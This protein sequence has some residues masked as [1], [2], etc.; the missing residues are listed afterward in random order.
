ML[1]WWLMK[2]AATLILLGA[3]LLSAQG[4]PQT[5]YQQI[6]RSFNSVNKRLLDMAKDFPEAKYNF[7]ATPDVRSFGEV[8]IHA[9]SGDVYAAKKGRGENVQW[10]EV[11][12]KQY[13]SKA[14][15]VAALEKAINDA[16]TTLNAIPPDRFKENVQPWVSVI[17]HCGEHYGQLVVYYRV[18]GLVP[19]GSR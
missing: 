17:E 4:A 6:Q 1:V 18:N 15:I 3:A 10:D 7:K 14:E 19:P 2:P 8:I 9:M 16:T 13:K 12:P 5:P 11:D